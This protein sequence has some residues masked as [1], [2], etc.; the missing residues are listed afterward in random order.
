MQ[1]LQIKDIKEKR[2]LE[3]I[4][5]DLSDKSLLDQGGARRVI[6]DILNLEEFHPE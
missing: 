3:K 1:H 2:D 6:N 5:L 4:L